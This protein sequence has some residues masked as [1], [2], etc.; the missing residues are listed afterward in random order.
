MN[1]VRDVSNIWY[2]QSEKSVSIWFDA[3]GG[4]ILE[5][6][7]YCT[8]PN[9]K[10]DVIASLRAE[11]IF[12]G[13]SKPSG[14]SLGHHDVRSLDIRKAATEGGKVFTINQT[15]YRSEQYVAY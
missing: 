14:I 12:E 3:R 15:E 5:V 8:S 2:T 10:I 13:D 11:R 7:L 4:A 6:T 9:A 1:F